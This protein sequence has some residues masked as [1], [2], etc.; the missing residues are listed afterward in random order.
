M[1]DSFFKKTTIMQKIQ[2]KMT[3]KGWMVFSLKHYATQGSSVPA[4]HTS[5]DE[6]TLLAEGVQASGFSVSSS[7]VS[8][9][10]HVALSLFVER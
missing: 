6:Q 2:L 10:S 7:S 5:S 3:S 8:E 1:E 4:L 9:G